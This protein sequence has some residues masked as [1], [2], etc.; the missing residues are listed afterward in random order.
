MDSY[1]PH[2]LRAVWMPLDGQTDRHCQGI[3]RLGRAASMTAKFCCLGNDTSFVDFGTAWLFCKYDSQFRNKLSVWSAHTKSF[4]VMH[5]AN[6]SEQMIVAKNANKVS[7]WHRKRRTH[8]KLWWYGRID[9]WM[10]NV[11]VR[12][13]HRVCRR[14]RCQGQVSSSCSC[15]LMWC[16]TRRRRWRC[17]Y[18]DVRCVV[19]M[20][21]RIGR[22]KFLMQLH[23][24]THSLQYMFLHLC[25]P[26]V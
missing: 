26:S 23:T 10:Y 11:V 15:S 6:I 4:S 12:Q 5:C 19:R 25:L 22:S 16:K 14:C 13:H 9:Y 24:S 21:A 2:C 8:R 3:A 18:A 7:D 17:W 20:S 1:R